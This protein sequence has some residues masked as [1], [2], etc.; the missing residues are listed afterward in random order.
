[1]ARIHDLLGIELPII[2]APM[3]GV[4]DSALVIAVS[5][6][7]GLGS[8]PCA[9]LSAD[10]MRAEL[11]AITSATRKPFNVNF[12]CHTP[13]ALDPEREAA[14]RDLL[15]PYYVEFGLD[16]S[17]VPA[18]PGRTPFS[19]EHIDVLSSFKPPVVS[20][21][22]GLPRQDLLQ[23]VRALGATILSSATTVE[24]ARWLKERGVDAIIAQG[25]EA[26]GHRGMFLSHDLTTQVGTLALVPQIVNAVGIPVI[27]AGGI[28]DSTGVA[29]AMAVGAAAVQIG[30]AYMLCPEATTSAVHRAALRSDAGRHTAL[31]NVFTGRPARGIVN[32]L[33]REIGPMNGLAPQFPL[34]AAAIAPLRGAAEARGSGDFSPLWSGQNTS[35][36]RDVPAAALTAE[37]ARG[38]VQ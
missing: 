29:A 11:A 6:A 2:Q 31:T 17:S 35:G 5:N 33:I 34:A 7:G 37:L 16:I 23:R 12:F 20:F 8:L 1:V 30:T 21:H 36:C 14:W 19:H 38:V 3:A 27:A 4:Q 26:G 9:M 18:G 22:F 15:R 32:R 24:E 13:P 25:L 10:T 28:A